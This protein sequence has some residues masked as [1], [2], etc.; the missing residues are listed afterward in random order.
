MFDVQI[1]RIVNY[2]RENKLLWVTS[3]LSYVCT[4]I[5]KWIICLCYY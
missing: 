2:Y 3:F 4:C 5:Y 1:L